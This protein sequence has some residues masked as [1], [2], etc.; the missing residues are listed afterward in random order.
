MGKMNI[1]EIKKKAYLEFL[2][3]L[4]ETPVGEIIDLIPSPATPNAFIKIKDKNYEKI[5]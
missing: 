2:K 5:K 4:A 1:T 3:R